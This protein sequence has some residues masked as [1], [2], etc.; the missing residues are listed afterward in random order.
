MNLLVKKECRIPKS[1][2]QKIQAQ[3]SEKITLSNFVRSILD[4]VK[5]NNL[6]NL[7]LTSVSC[8][9]K[10]R[11]KISSEKSKEIDEICRAKNVTISQ[12]IRSLLETENYIINQF[13][14]LSL[15]EIEL[16]RVGIMLNNIAHEL[17]RLNLQSEINSET[18]D[19][20]TVRLI[21]PL[22]IVENITFL[23]MNPPII[24][25]ESRHIYQK[26]TQ[27]RWA[28]QIYRITNN[29][30]QITRRVSHDYNIISTERYN[31]III[32]LNQFELQFKQIFKSLKIFNKVINMYTSGLSNAD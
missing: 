1:T 9:D 28:S 4:D 17:N 27:L 10:I 14:Y 31:Q 13:E 12:L 15:C 6:D 30:R 2:K 32:N 18:Y 25:K 3:I 5:I 8:D 16:N 23:L 20:L 19:L 26:K 7:S 24:N 21:E 22:F 29:I 11:F